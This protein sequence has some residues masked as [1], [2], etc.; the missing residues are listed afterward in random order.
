MG[1]KMGPNF[2][3]G[4]ASIDDAAHTFFHYERLV[5]ERRNLQAKV[6]VYIIEHFCDVIL[7]GE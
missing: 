5:L 1:K 3:Y 4:D 7:N 6:G 2:I